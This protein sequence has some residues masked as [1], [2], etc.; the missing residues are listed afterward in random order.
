MNTNNVLLTGRVA[1]VKEYDKYT[2]LKLTVT[3]KVATRT[4]ERNV[5]NYPAVFWFGDNKTI[6]AKFK[7]FDY[8]KI[9]GYISTYVQSQ[10]GQTLLY[11][12]IVGTSIEPWITSNESSK[13]NRITIYGSV[14][15]L[16]LKSDSYAEFTLA[17]ETNLPNENEPIV[18]FPTFTAF[19]KVAEFMKTQVRKGSKVKISASVE[20][21][22]CKRGTDPSDSGQKSE[23]KYGSSKEIYVCNQITVMH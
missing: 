4:T 22:V 20:T 3:T 9:K 15:S 14:A 19:N 2:L 21:K 7:Q 5:S 6:A 8:V 12:N 11:Q 13:T 16:T 23:K 1:F 17:V 18:F 10:N